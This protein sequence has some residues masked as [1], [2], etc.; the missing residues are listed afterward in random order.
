MALIQC[1]FFSDVLGLSMTMNVILPQNTQSQIGM[2]GKSREGKLPCLWLLHGYSDDQGAWMRRTS[3]ERYVADKGIAVVMPNVH[4]SYYTDLVQGDKYWQYISEEIP[5]LARSFFPISD[6]R[7]DNYVAGLS[8]GG[9]GAFKLALNHPD[10]YA[11]AASLSGA[12]DNQWFINNNNGRD[13]EPTFGSK[14][15]FTGSLND[16]NHVVQELN[17]SGKDKPRLFQC[18]GTED[19]LYEGNCT[20]RDLMQDLDYDY[21]YEEGPGS[22]EWGYWDTNIQRI[23]EW[24]D[25]Q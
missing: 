22:H 7:E 23:L 1:D 11:A 13:F 2:E 14:E 10:R 6:K 5:A 25:V 8:M 12:I 20:F 18:C 4:K 16:L 9:Y 15:K 24:M 19:F 3:I 21:T 17:A